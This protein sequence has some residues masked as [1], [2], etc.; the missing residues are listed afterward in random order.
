MSLFRR[1]PDA[2]V[3]LAMAPEEL[4]SVLLRM[5]RSFLALNKTDPAARQ[6]SFIVYWSTSIMGQ[7]A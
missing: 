3:L 4:A 6:V 2:D 1:V 7:P 5:A